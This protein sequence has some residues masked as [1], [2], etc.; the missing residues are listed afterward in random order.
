LFTQN[1]II[2]KH[3][4]RV[5]GFDILLVLDSKVNDSKPIC[6]IDISTL[7]SNKLVV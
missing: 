3:G 5:Y 6:D 2:A 4:C 1:T 7:R